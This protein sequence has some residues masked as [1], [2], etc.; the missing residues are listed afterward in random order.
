MAT[1]KNT[2]TSPGK[3]QRTRRHAPR[4]LAAAVVVL[5]AAVCT[6]AQAQQQQNRRATGTPSVT[7]ADGT[8]L[9]T[10]APNVGVQLTAAQGSVNDADGID[11]STINWAW[12]RA[13]TANG[14]ISFITGAR[15]ATFTPGQDL[16]G[17]YL[18]VCMSFQDNH[19]LKNTEQRCW[20]IPRAVFDPD[21]P[22]TP[23]GPGRPILTKPVSA[24]WETED[25]TLYWRPPANSGS[26]PI[27]G[28]RIFREQHDVGYYRNS[29]PTACDNASFGR[30]LEAYAFT[31]T[32]KSEFYEYTVNPSNAAGATFGNCYRWKIA[33]VNGAG[34]GPAATTD[35]ILARGYTHGGAAYSFDNHLDNGV[36]CPA[37][38]FRPYAYNNEWAGACVPEGHI[39]R[40]EL[41]QFLR[42]RGEII[43]VSYQSGTSVCSA[44]TLAYDGYCEELGYVSDSFTISRANC[45]MPDRCGV[46]SEYNA[47]HRECRCENWAEPAANT[48][49]GSPERCSCNV[50]GAD[51]SCECPA[52]NPYVPSE[53]RCGCPMGE[54]YNAETTFCEVD[55]HSSDLAAEV[56]KASPSLASV[57]ALLSAGADPDIKAG[58]VPVLLTAAALGHSDV[59]SVLIT[60]GADPAATNPLFYD[61]NVA[62][63]MSARDGSALTRTQKKD[64]L[65][66][67]AGGLD[68]A[69][70]TFDWNAGDRNNNRPMNL[71]RTR[72]PTNPAGIWT[73]SRK[74][75]TLCWRAGG[76]VRRGALRRFITTRALEVWGRRW[77]TW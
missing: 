30:S 70:A 31:V 16:V 22:T 68:V 58:T 7:A 21:G 40:A 10:T 9:S 44:T 41:C 33:A 39:G 67:F 17:K 19:R 53:H 20:R 2:T 54:R 51:A 47:D 76:G 5:V 32:V 28:Y 74:W 57:R 72:S 75:R 25:F 42:L 66:H 60:A 26:T 65:E 11:H 48:D 8:N 49:A 38:E 14:A 34:V 43:A 45:V 24:D 52:D 73:S 61:T 1:L 64:V 77:R 37:G 69:G 63:F 59:V 27:T 50:A 3:Q 55:P 13:D 15:S 6:L 46:L 4:F 56:V 62:H 36:A 12:Q 71:L 35:P 18:Q 29:H 23:G